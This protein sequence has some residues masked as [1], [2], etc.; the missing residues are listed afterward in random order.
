MEKWVE[1][2]QIPNGGIKNIWSCEILATSLRRQRQNTDT[3]LTH[4]T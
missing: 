4:T 3:V 2:G 1:K